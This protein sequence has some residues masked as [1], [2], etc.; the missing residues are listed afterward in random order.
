MQVPSKIELGTSD[1]T[2]VRT[3]LVSERYI[4]A[5]YTSEVS[6]DYANMN[7]EWVANNVIESSVLRGL[8]HWQ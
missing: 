7:M 2:R 3:F 4:F 8:I 1:G 6:K 5:E